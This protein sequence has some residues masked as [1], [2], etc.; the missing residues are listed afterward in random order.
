MQMRMVAVQT[1]P[2]IRLSAAAFVATAIE[3]EELDMLNLIQLG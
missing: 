2:G 3:E 1:E